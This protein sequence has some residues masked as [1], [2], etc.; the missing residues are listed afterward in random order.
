MST[1]P[2]QRAHPNG[3]PTWLSAHRALAVLLAGLITLTGCSSALARLPRDAT[4]AT[5]AGQSPA[6]AVAANPGAQPLQ[7]LP[8]ADWGISDGH[9]YTQPNG[10]PALTSPTGFAVT[11]QDGIPFWN[12]FQR[13]G[14][15][16]VLGYP[17]S[18][19]FSYR[20]KTT[21][22]YNRAVF[23][24]NAE[25]RKVELTNILTD[26][27]EA[28]KGDWLAQTYRVPARVPA[29]FD[30]GKNWDQ[31]VGDRLALLKS[32][33]AIEDK[34][35]SAPDPMAVYGLPDSPVVDQGDHLAVRLQR[36]VLRLWK[37]DK[38]FAKAGEVTADNSGDWAI[39]AGLFPAEPLRPEQPPSV[40]FTLD[41][42]ARPV[43]PG[44]A[45]APAPAPTAAPSPAPAPSATPAL[46]A[47]A[48]V[49]QVAETGGDGVFLRRTPRLDDKVRAWPDGTLMKGLGE[50]AQGDGITWQKVQSPD[51]T[52]GYVPLRYLKPKQ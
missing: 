48:S 30:S 8:A 42:A 34:Y 25:V 15:T 11:N 44:G 35:R 26:I 6:G 4:P 14:G 36:T 27:E 41:L 51:G 12:E 19:R 47:Q 10:Q 16:A 31:I 22:V 9:F 38:P 39:K 50:Q 40:P 18:S 13:L 24:W 20:G 52:V 49:W 46:A 23:Q 17:V 37:Q 7:V 29:S 28:G 3:R 45:G 21:Q 1:R 5:S 2:S 43:G 33:K 32:A